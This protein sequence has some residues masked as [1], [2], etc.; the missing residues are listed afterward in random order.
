MGNNLLTTYE[1]N[2]E[3]QVVKVLPPAYHAHRNI[4]TLNQVIAYTQLINQ[5]KNN[6]QQRNIQD[7]FSTRMI[8]DKNGQIIER[9]SPDTKKQILIY[10]RENLLRFILQ[11]DINNKPYRV[12]YYQYDK[13]GDLSSQGY[14]T[15]CLNYE[16]LQNLANNY[17]ELPQAIPYLQMI[18]NNGSVKAN[19]RSKSVTSVI[20]QSEGIWRESSA[21]L[22]EGKLSNKEIMLVSDNLW[23]IYRTD[24]TYYGA[25]VSTITYPMLFKNQ[26]LIISYSYNKQNRTVA[27]GTPNNLEQWT[28]FTYTAHGQISNEIHISNNFTTYYDYNSPGYL[29]NIRNKYINET[30]YYTQGSYGQGGYFDGTIARTQFKTQ[31]FSYCDTRLLS[32]TA[33][34]FQQ[35]LEAIGQNITLGKAEYYLQTLQNTG[36]LD[37]NRRVIKTFLPREAALY[38]PRECG[39]TFAYALAETLNEYFVQDYGHQYSYGNHMELIKAKYFIGD[40]NLKPIQP[41][42]FEEKSYKINSQQSKSIWKILVDEIYIWPDND[43]GIHLQ[44]KVNTNKWIDYETLKKNLGKF[45][46]YDHVLATILQKYISQR[47]VLTFGKLQKIFLTWLTVDLDTQKETIDIYLETAKQIWTILSNQGYLYSLNSLCTLFTNHFYQILKDYRMFIPE[48][49]GVLQEN[50]SWQ[51]GESACDVEAYM[52]DENGNHRH[53]WTGYSR[54]VLHYKENNNQIENIDYKSM[55]R[56]KPATSFKITHDD[57]GNITKAEHKGITEIIYHPTS[58]RPI[59]IKL[60]DGR[61]VSYDYDVQGERVRKHIVN[62]KGEKLKEILYLRDEEGRSLVEKEMNF[63]NA[64]HHEQCTGYIYGPKGLIGFIR[65]DEFYSVICDHEGSVRLII[66]NEEVVAAYD[67]LPYGNLIRE[68]GI[69]QV[70]ISYRYT[71]QE[72]D[73]ETGLYN[74]HARLYDPDIG[75]FYQIDPQGQYAS[76]Y[77]YAGNSPVSM[78]DP[79]GELAFIPLLMLGFAVVGGHLGG[80]SVNNSWDIR[81]WDLANPGTYLGIVGGALTGALA[82]VGLTISVAAIANFGLS[83]ATAAAATS[84]LG[85]GG[86]YLGMASASQTWNPLQWQWSRPMIWSSGFQG[87]TFGAS[88]VGGVGN[89]YQYYRY[90]GTAGK[91]AFAIGCVASS[92]GM[93][94]FSMASATNSWSPR[95]WKLTS[96]TTVFAG[97]GGAFGGLMAPLGLLYTGKSITYLQT[98]S[99]RIFIGCGTLIPG[100]TCSYL[101][102]SAANDSFTNWDMSSPKTYESIIGGFLFGISL[103]GLPKALSDGMKKTSK[104]WKRHE[105]YQKEH[106]KIDQQL[107]NEIV[108]KVNAFFGEGNKKL[109]ENGVISIAT[110]EDGTKLFAYSGTEK[111]LIVDGIIDNNGAKIIRVREVLPNVGGGKVVTFEHITKKLGISKQYVLRKSGMPNEQGRNLPRAPEICAEPRTMELA[112]KLGYANNDIAS[113]SAFRKEATGVVPV[114]ACRNCQVYVPGKVYTEVIFGKAFQNPFD[115]MIYTAQ[116]SIQQLQKKY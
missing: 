93:T 58:N 10:N 13:F 88:I 86:M 53:Y 21:Y 54:Y 63:T 85:V 81:E 62:S 64:G 38:L 59:I 1:Y 74:Y 43:D 106:Y 50:S 94:Y 115:Y 65:N 12:I 28:K 25:N 95:E 66:K 39:G 18:K 80:A 87:F 98:I 8:Y 23:Q 17:S 29:E 107:A 14:S 40:M 48:I 7:K 72:W 20:N 44:G 99:S 108:D 83:V 67:Y 91:C 3:N 5:W 77:K 33:Q 41:L 51:T 24:Y 76:L 56:D 96:P 100:G 46:D 111:Y 68:Y 75:R 109:S 36:F 61:Q 84:A 89:W 27:I 110:M 32:L 70:Q 55:S 114:N 104:A 47:E 11:H 116:I 82:P 71:G 60:Q 34:N 69:P 4:N 15:E 92:T 57:L 79:D 6:E 105:Y 45:S 52:I 16:D 35:R 103:P 19:L 73:E 101:F 30:I 78:V 2:D 102:A 90:L 112:F 49:I 97:L 42:S 26:P 113:F 37:K 31:W 22:H 9:I